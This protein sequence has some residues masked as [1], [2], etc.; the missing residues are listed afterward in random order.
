M[1]HKTFIKFASY[2]RRIY[3]LKVREELYATFNTDFKGQYA[4]ELIKNILLDDKPAMIAR[5]GNSELQTL[6]NYLEITESKFTKYYKYITY[7]SNNLEWKR[8][9]IEL[10]TVN[11]GFFPDTPEHIE[12]YCKAFI[13]D[14]SKIDILGSWLESEKKVEKFYSENLK[15]VGFADLEPYYH[16]KPWTK[17]LEGKNVLVI[18]PFEDSIIKQYEKRKFLFKDPNVLPS[19]NLKTIK[20]VQTIAG[21]NQEKYRD[22]FHALDIMKEQMEKTDFDIAL[23]GCGAYGLPLAAHAKKIGK[24]G[25]HLGGATQVLF[26][27]IG[28]R[29]LNSGGYKNFNFHNEHWIRPSKDET[30]KNSDKIE[31]AT[32]W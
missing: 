9:N 26:G 16:Q 32:Y 15:T 21:N 11:A 27:I 6:V 14:I 31:G 12:K 19:F 1:N 8:H 20:S 5:F 23:I 30:P 4:N 7:Q 29:W 3:P 25:F 17:A 18:H 2:L 10:L 24:K 22:W 28:D 13:D